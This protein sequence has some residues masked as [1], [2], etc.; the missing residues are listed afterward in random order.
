M[1]EKLREAIRKELIDDENNLVAFLIS[2]NA[3]VE[4]F[5]EVQAEGRVWS[6]EIDHLSSF[7]ELL[8]WEWS[9]RNMGPV[10]FID[11]VGLLLDRITA[12]AAH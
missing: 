1:L 3:A 6:S 8:N 2:T 10:E 9:V 5:D 12:E 4:A 11:H 7:N